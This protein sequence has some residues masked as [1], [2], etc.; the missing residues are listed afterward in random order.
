MDLIVKVPISKKNEQQSTA[1]CLAALREQCG[2]MGWAGRASWLEE[3]EQKAGW[4]QKE[5]AQRYQ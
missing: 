2:F 4:L 5:K 3:M 1:P